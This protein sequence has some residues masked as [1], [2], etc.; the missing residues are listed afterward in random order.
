MKFFHFGSKIS[1]N[2]AYELSF[3]HIY[4]CFDDGIDFINFNVE[5]S[6]FK[7]DHN[8]TFSILFV[9]FNIAIIDFTIHNVNHL[10]E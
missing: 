8:P 1:K 2:Y 9:F 3:M 4:R 6:I 5:L 7:A 10:K